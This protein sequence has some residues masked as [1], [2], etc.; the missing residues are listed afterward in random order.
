MGDVCDDDELMVESLLEPRKFGLVVERHF[1]AIHAYLSRRVGW[2]LADD[3]AADTFSIAFV[4]RQTYVLGQLCAL[5]WLYGIAT[6]LARNHARAEARFLRAL[7]RLGAERDATD[8]TDDCLER[9]TAL[10]VAPQL[11]AG[12]RELQCGD[13]DVLLLRAWAD[14][15]YKEIAVALGIPIGTVRSRL[16]RARLSLR[17]S[18]G[19]LDLLV[20]KGQ[21]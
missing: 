14:L 12:L 4:R 10:S 11:L 3:L 19:R 8:Q 15:S 16:A 18:L 5:P 20:E 1:S 9:E 6:N 7:P 17:G 2:S 13:R 21:Q